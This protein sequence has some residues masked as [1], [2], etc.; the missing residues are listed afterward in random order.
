M[1]LSNDGMAGTAPNVPAECIGANKLGSNAAP[2][3]KCEASVEGDDYHYTETYIAD[4]KLYAVCKNLNAQ[5]IDA[6]N[7]TEAARAW[8]SAVSIALTMMTQLTNETA[9]GKDNA[10]RIDSIMEQNSFKMM[11]SAK[12]TL[13]EAFYPD[14]PDIVNELLSNHVLNQLCIR[15]SAE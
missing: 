10:A 8:Q 13:L 7:E 5:L 3:Q 11:L 6:V 12:R 15:M 14:A 9:A 1:R 2:A 4:A